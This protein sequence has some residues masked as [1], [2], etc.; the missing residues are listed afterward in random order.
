MRLLVT[1]SNGFLGSRCCKLAVARGWKVAAMTRENSDLALLR[2]LLDAEKIERRVG[3]LAD[4]ATHARC[5][6]GCEVILNA[7]AATSEH[8]SDLE[9]SRR[10]NVEGTR[11]F[12][13]AAREAGVGRVAHISSQSAHPGNRSAYGQTKLESEA[14][15]QESGIGWTILRPGVIYGPEERGVFAKLE[16]HIEKLPVIPVIGNGRY[17]QYPVHVDDVA[18]AALDCLENAACAGQTFDI[19][20]A[21]ALEFLEV[22]DAVMDAKGVRKPKLRLPV[23]VCRLIADVSG[24]LTSNPPLTRDNI[25]GLLTAPPLDNGPAGE[26]FGYAPRGFREGFRECVEERLSSSPTS[27]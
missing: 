9:R 27:R 8:S 15:V 6:A 18:N 2:P 16:N 5:V 3:D 24:A 23:W 11:A 13:A 25:E 20:G 19:A 7:A 21:D 10:V 14:V 12:L 1:G 4:P 26:A 17:R 22:L